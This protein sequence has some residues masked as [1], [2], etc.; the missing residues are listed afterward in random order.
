[1][2][3]HVNSSCFET[4]DRFVIKATKFAALTIG[5]TRVFHT[6]NVLTAEIKM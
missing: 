4:L 3:L 5:I 6:A 1:M 2:Q